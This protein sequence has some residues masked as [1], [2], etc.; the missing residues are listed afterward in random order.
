MRALKAIPLAIALSLAAAPAFARPAPAK[1]PAG[2]PT[3]PA[4]AKNDKAKT[5]KP[6]ARETRA[7]EAMK[8]E[9]IDEA[10]A[11][12]VISVVKKYRQERQPVQKEMQTQREALRTLLANDSSDQPAYSKALDAIKAGQKKLQEIKEREVS[13]I[14][15]ILK[16]S[17]QAKVLRLL[18][19]AKHKGAGTG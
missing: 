14:Q 2:S 1:P 4:K 7:V 6:G 18:L 5:D 11:K 13:E 3:R 8:R 17:E 12:R 19:R 15:Q 9:G 16:P 10:R